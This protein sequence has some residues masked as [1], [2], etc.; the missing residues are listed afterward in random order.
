MFVQTRSY[1]REDA[2]LPGWGVRGGAG[3]RRETGGNSK[4]G[5]HQDVLHSSGAKAGKQVMPYRL[6][7]ILLY[8]HERSLRNMYRDRV[9]L[10]DG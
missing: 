2:K 1:L 5:W 4:D 3:V 10:L 7:I 6:Q 9:T 8:H